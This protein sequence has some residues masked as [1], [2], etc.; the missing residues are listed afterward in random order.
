M[1]NNLSVF[2]A[3]EATFQKLTRL[4]DKC[5]T[6]YE[7]DGCIRFPTCI[8]AWDEFITSFAVIRTPSFGENQLASLA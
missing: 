3:R 7:C 6:V 4:L 1:A 8:R 5:S 2:E